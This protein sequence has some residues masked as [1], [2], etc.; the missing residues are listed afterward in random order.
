[1]FPLQ[2]VIREVQDNAY[3]RMSDNNM[4]N[5]GIQFLQD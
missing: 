2:A 5:P 1:M 4:S 3:V